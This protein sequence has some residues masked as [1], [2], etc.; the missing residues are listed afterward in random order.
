MAWTKKV[1]HSSLAVNR[2][3]APEFL[4]FSLFGKLVALY[5][6]YT[7]VPCS[8]CIMDIVCTYFKFN[9]RSLTDTPGQIWHLKIF[10]CPNSLG[11]SWDEK[12]ILKIFLSCL[13]SEIQLFVYI[14][15]WNSKWPPEYYNLT[16]FRQNWIKNKKFL[17]L[18]HFL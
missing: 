12:N 1:D 6:F 3:V 16:K 5:T 18:G 14:F 2:G 13:L 8:V 15:G 9:S 7:P 4:L 11:T 17:L 10:Y